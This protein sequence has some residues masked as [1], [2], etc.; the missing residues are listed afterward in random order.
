MKTEAGRSASRQHAVANL[1]GIVAK[2]VEGK[3]SQRNLRAKKKGGNVEGKW[4]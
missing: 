3:L 1:F 4:H 2:D